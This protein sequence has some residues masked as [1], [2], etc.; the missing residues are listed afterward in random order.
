M[1][2]QKM[3][4]KNFFS[5]YNSALNALT[6]AM[7]EY[8]NIHNAA[9]DAVKEIKKLTELSRSMFSEIK[10]VWF[11]LRNSG[12]FIDKNNNDMLKNEVTNLADVKPKVGSNGISTGKEHSDDEDEDE[13]EE[14][15]CQ[16]QDNL[17]DKTLR[18]LEAARTNKK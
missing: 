5:R 18:T 9:M 10:I 15:V 8:Q 11:D 17:P 3:F 14:E 6:H 1:M 12:T 16:V 7:E 4:D 2:S 13:N